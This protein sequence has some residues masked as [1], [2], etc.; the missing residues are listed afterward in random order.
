MASAHNAELSLERA[1]KYQPDVILMG[2]NLPG[3]NGIEALYKLTCSKKT[4][5]IPVIALPTNAMKGNKKKGLEAGF[6]GYL[7]KPIEVLAGVNAALEEAIS[8]QAWGNR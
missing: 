6:C 5:Y 7:T 2:I 1:H 3:M 4:R 8:R